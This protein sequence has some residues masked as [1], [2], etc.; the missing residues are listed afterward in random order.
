[1]DGAIR[2]GILSAAKNGL[3]FGLVFLADIFDEEEAV[4]NS[5]DS[6]DSS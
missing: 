2:L 3:L 1:V 5:F 4:K 6:L